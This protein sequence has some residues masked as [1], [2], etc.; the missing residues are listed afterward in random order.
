[1]NSPLLSE[2]N[3]SIITQ[4]MNIQCSNK[5]LDHN[6]TKCKLLHI[7]SVV[8]VAEKNFFV[9]GRMYVWTHLL[10]DISDPSNV[11][12]STQRRPN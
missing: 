12:R 10:T 5:S 7:C 8:T 3:K 1:M 11:I 2:K 9:K 4:Q 6:Y